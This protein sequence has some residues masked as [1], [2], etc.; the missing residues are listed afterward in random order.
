MAVMKAER[1]AQTILKELSHIIQF[2]LKDNKVGFV[3]ITDVRVTNDLSQAKVYVNFLGSEDR[4]SAGLKALE[5]SKGFLR[6][7][8]A[9]KL[10]MRK[11]PELIFVIDDSLAKGNRIEE[12]LKEIKDK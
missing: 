9:K 8:L 4:E 1:L 11:V 7:E 6:S 10:T 2:E 3:T 12:L 5:R